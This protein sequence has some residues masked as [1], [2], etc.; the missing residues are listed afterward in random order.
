M[1][2]KK[3]WVGR[4]VIAEHQAFLEWEENVGWEASLEPIWS[5]LLLK[6]YP[7][8]A[9]AGIFPAE[10][11]PSVLCNLFQDCCCYLQWTGFLIQTNLFPLFPLDFYH[12]CGY[13]LGTG[14]LGLVFPWVFS[15]LGWTKMPSS[16]VPSPPKVWLSWCL[17]AAPFPCFIVSLELGD[18]SWTKYSRRGLRRVKWVGMVTFPD[19]CGFSL[20]DA[21]QGAV[22]SLAWQGIFLVRFVT[23]KSPKLKPN[24]RQEWSLT[25]WYPTRCLH[26]CLWSY[27]ISF[28]LKKIP[29]YLCIAT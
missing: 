15:V 21:T 29:I 28:S 19:L 23:L 17:S 20:A 18:Q 5:N 6:G 27:N 2:F 12:F 7:C 3:G 16:S 24:S 8:Q 4:N 11:A 22:S 25:I 1:C 10:K 26:A 14:S 13:L 9:E